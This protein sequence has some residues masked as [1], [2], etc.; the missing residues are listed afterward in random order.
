MLAYS[1]CALRSITFAYELW[2]G[3]WF[4]CQ[5]S[6][7]P[8]TISASKFT[9]YQ[10]HI[11]A[12]FFFGPAAIPLSHSSQHLSAS[13]AVQYSTS[14]QCLCQLLWVMTILAPCAICVLGKSQKPQVVH[15][16][17]YNFNT[18]HFLIRALIIWYITPFSSTPSQILPR[19]DSTRTPKKFN[20]C[21]CIFLM[22]YCISCFS[23]RKSEPKT[24]Y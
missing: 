9:F 12:V 11:S 3:T 21:P 4:S 19:D 22:I 8:S 17:F 24:V 10:Y 7:T 16:T 1:S 15:Y 23:P 14:L 6:L 2:G 20:I 5:N 13:Y 18:L